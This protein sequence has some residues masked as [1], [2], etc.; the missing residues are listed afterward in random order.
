MSY[1]NVHLNLLQKVI[2]P[3][4]IT[5]SLLSGIPRPT[6]AQIA[7]D[8]TLPV[9]TAVSQSDNTFTITNGTQAG[10][11]LFHSFGQFSV[12]T[13]GSAVFNTSQYSGIQ[14]I[15]SRV[16]GGSISS[17]DGLIQATPRVNLFLLNPNGIVFGP[18]A[19]LSLGGSFLATTGSSIR[20][21]DG[22]EFSAN[23]QMSSVLTVSV[24]IGVQF[25]NN[26]GNI[27]VSGSSLSTPNR[28]LGLLGGAV[29]TEGGTS[30]LGGSSIIQATSGRL[31]LGSVGGNSFVSLRLFD[32]GFALSYSPGT[33][34]Q[35]IN[36]AQNSYLA[37]LDGGSIQV[38]GRQI[39]LSGGSQFDVSNS[40]KA[41]LPGGTLSVNGSESVEILG[42]GIYLL[43][44]GP[45]EAPTGLFN[46]NNSTQ[47]PGSLT[48]N[49]ET[50]RITDGARIVTET[51][52]TR[53]GGNATIN[54][55]GLVEVTGVST[56][57]TF[58]SNISVASLPRA[59]GTA[60]NLLINTDLLQISN[61]G[62]VSATT[63][64]NG[65]GGN[66]TVNAGTVQLTGGR[67][68][69]VNGLFAQAGSSNAQ[70]N[71]PN[72]TGQGGNLTVNTDR[73]I[74]QNGSLVSTRTFTAG[75][76]GNLTVNADR[77]LVT[78]RS[79]EDGT[80]SLITASSAGRG[81]AGNLSIFADQVRVQNGGQITVSGTSTGVAGNMLIASPLIELN[82]RGAL[83]AETRAGQGNITLNT[84]DLRLRNNSLISTNA[85]GAATGGN[86]RISTKTLVALE[87]S[88]ITANA[89]ESFG[90]RVSIQA[91]AIFGT[92]YRLFLTPK[93]DITATSA[94]GPEFSGVVFLQTPG[95]DPSQGLVQLQTD[96]VDVSQLVKDAC[97]PTNQQSRGEFFVT[98]RGG[99][100]ASPSDVVS[101]DRVLV[102]LGARQSDRPPSSNS[103]TTLD[104]PSSVT[105]PTSDRTPL[106]QAQGWVVNT[107]GKVVLVAQAATTG[108]AKNLSVQFP[109]C[110]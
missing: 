34:Y 42:T 3:S 55:S 47:S 48:V 52:S 29:N 44:A 43:R 79:L 103:A 81:A 66:L 10:S 1:F 45:T 74:V 62:Q 13:G 99:L 12:P 77:V 35:D 85:T 20:F 86:I 96:V 16:T 94:L 39:R 8:G 49:T 75:N 106:L 21:A 107:A 89:Q 30:G 110:K 56:S 84:S 70:N 87:N 33:T 90:G 76:A 46:S 93:S 63:F 38:Q 4:L 78:G 57:G 50:L 31:E 24:P 60:G 71:I 19:T 22:T 101:D 18:S 41:T 25:S 14:T 68:G 98:G 97:S 58:F 73:L 51:S 7:G 91:T 104:L 53:E 17:I 102:D 95:I 54:A 92:Q 64:G 23:P 83:L 61:G 40:D 5:I 105:Q 37:S 27:R 67:T 2:V 9:P 6:I 69:R 59:T 88:D 32:Q 80:P 108:T 26:P 28:T 11:N 36:V 100:P 82:N 65:Q 72:A 15:F 109:A